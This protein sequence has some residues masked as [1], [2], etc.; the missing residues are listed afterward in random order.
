MSFFDC[1]HP[2]IPKV[3]HPKLFWNTIPFLIEYVK[4]ATKLRYFE[5]SAARP[6]ARAPRLRPVGFLDGL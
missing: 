1:G 6:M 3:T 2:G 4:Y 5:L